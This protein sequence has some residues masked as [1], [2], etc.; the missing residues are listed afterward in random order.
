MTLRNSLLATVFCILLFSSCDDDDPRDNYPQTHDI[1]FSVTSSDNSRQ[2]VVD[3]S[4]IGEGVEISDKSVGNTH[5][6]YKKDFFNQRIPFSTLLGISYQD[7]SGGAIGVP[8]VPYTIKITIKVGS[9]IKAEKEIEITE[10]RLI[11]STEYIF[12]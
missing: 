3:V 8:F 10:S 5:L 7:N 2:S 6:P 4:I 11:T 12:Y 1:S 9:E